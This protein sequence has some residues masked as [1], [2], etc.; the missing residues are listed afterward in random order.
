MHE[1]RSRFFKEIFKNKNPRNKINY[2]VFSQ[3]VTMACGDI[4][5]DTRINN[6][7]KLYYEDLKVLLNVLKKEI[8]R[9]GKMQS[10]NNNYIVIPKQIEKELFGGYVFFEYEGVGKIGGIKIKGIVDE[11]IELDS[12]SFIIRDF[13]SYDYDEDINPLDSNSKL[14]RDFMQICVYGLIF[15][16]DRYQRCESIQLV[17]FPNKVVEYEFTEELK[18]KARKFALDTAFEGFEG[19]SF[20]FQLNETEKLINQSDLN[21][22]FRENDILSS[23][24]ES[25]DCLGWID[26]TKAKPLELIN[27]KENKLQ[28][29]LYSNKAKKVR[30]GYCLIVETDKKI[31]V[32]CKVEKIE[33]FEQHVSGETASHKEEDYKIILNPK[34]EFTLEGC[35]DVTPQ[36]IIKGKIMFPMRREIYEY[37]K[38]PLDGLPIGT[39]VGLNDS[40][41]YHFDMRLLF[42]SIF[43]GGVQETGKTSAIKYQTL[44]L[45][46]TSNSPKILILDNEGEYRDLIKIPTTER[47]R[48]LMNKLKIKSID[49]NDFSLIEIG[50]DE[51]FCLTLKA[52]DPLDF[53]YLLRDLTPITYD[54]LLTIIYDIIK[55]TQKEEFTL[56]ELKKQIFEYLAKAKYDLAK[57]TKS[58]IRRA[59]NSVSLKIFDVLG[60]KPIN[61]MSILSSKKVI[62]INSH[63]LRDYHQRIVGLY[64]LAMLHR[65]A[66]KGQQKLGIVFILD[67]IQRLIPKSKSDSEYQKRIIGFLDEVVHRGRKRDYGVIFATQSPLDVKKEIID[68]CNTKMFFQIQG[69]TSFILREYLNKEER[70]R[71]KKLIV[72]EA[73]ITSKG[74]HEPVR[75]KFPFIN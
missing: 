61:L 23:E 20:D 40:Y 2:R 66:M 4:L 35:R 8:L 9:V 31:R 72:G 5:A 19:V 25:N 15:E 37:K 36:T 51:G 47:S 22:N 69:E 67:E 13:K 53:P 26:T 1:S 59:L 33:C 45:A 34:V 48:N 39:L 43:M 38:L 28:G 52:I 75:I 46:Q 10:K 68:L 49:P 17:Y 41:L 65:V 71:L 58:A 14:H 11:L 21:V 73:F 24:F 60:V 56:P 55:D 64:L 6:D 50:A 63:N 12:S 70:E 29:F 62:V 42:Q 27:G 30:D 3:R 18:E 54:S 44:M 16:Q 74:K 32:M 7:Y 57:G